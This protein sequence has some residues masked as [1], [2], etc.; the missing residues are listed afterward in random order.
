M[1]TNKLTEVFNQLQKSGINA[2]IKN[3]NETLLIWAVSEGYYE[4]AY[5]LIKAGADL[6][7]QNNDGNTA[8]IRAACE[9]RIDLA[10]ALIE[11]G[12]RLDIQNNQGYTALILTKRRGNM[13]IYD[14]LLKAGADTMLQ[15]NQG[16]TAAATRVGESPKQSL[17]A[18]RD[19]DLELQIIQKIG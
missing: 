18:P 12:A 2:R 5:A 6:D 19:L 16:A 4:I 7:A 9:N 13:E 8:L 10:R 17:T 14:L 1:E 15:T 3:R 11:A